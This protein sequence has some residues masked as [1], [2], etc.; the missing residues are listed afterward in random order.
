MVLSE[1]SRTIGLRPDSRCRSMS[2]SRDDGGVGR[3][4]PG[5]DVADDARFAVSPCPQS[6]SWVVASSR[7]W[8][9]RLAAGNVAPL[10]DERPLAG[11]RRHKPGHRGRLDRQGDRP[12][13]GQSR[14]GRR[15]PSD[16]TRYPAAIGRR[17]RGPIQRLVGPARTSLA[18][19]SL[20]ALTGK[21][22]TRR[23]SEDQRRLPD[24]PGNSPHDPCRP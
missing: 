17:P 2:G 5:C 19:Q 8:T 6:P 3:G 12:R 13:A 15:T 18:R 23:S 7:P 21:S 14:G 20:T 24:P 22:R 16:P 9:A 4:A 10:S 1:H 11:T